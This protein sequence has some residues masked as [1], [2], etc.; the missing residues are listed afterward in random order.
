[1]GK[2]LVIIESA[3]KLKKMKSILGEKYE[4]MASF[5]HILD[6]KEG[7]LSV[8]IKNNF[9]PEYDILKN[10]KKKG[11]NLGFKSKE[12]IVKELK[13]MAKKCSEVLL[14]TD[15]DREGEMIAWSLAHVLGLTDPKRVTFN[16]ITKNEVLKAVKSPKKI[17]NN[18]VDAQRARRILDRIVGFEISPI[19]WKTIQ[20]SLSAGRVQSVVVK[21]IVDKENDISDYFKKNAETYFKGNGVFY[22]KKNNNM[23]A[24]LYQLN[25]SNDESDNDS[26]SDEESN[27]DSDEESNSDSDE[28]K[29]DSDTNSENSD[30]E[31]IKKGTIAK[32]K[33][34][35][36][37]KEIMKK[38]ME[39]KYKIS[40][41]LEK[42]STRNPSAPFI[43]STLQQEAANKLG[44]PVKK[45]MMS[46][47]KLYEAGYI[48]YMRT[49]S[50][51]LSPEAMANI[52]KYVLDKF[53]KEYYRSMDYKSK[54]KNSQEAHEAIRPTDV[55][56]EKIETNEKIGGDEKRLYNLILKRTIASQMSPAKFNVVDIIIDISK[57]I[58]YYYMARTE[59]L[60]FAGFLRI[61]NLKN[62]D[63]DVNNNGEEDIDE[64]EEEEE[65]E[66][67]DKVSIPKKGTILGVD[68]IILQQD[69][70]KPPIRYNEAS[71]V[72]KLEKLGIGRPSTY[73]TNIMKIQE[74]GYVEVKN[75]EGIKK[76]VL[77][78]KWNGKGKEVKEIKKE[79]VLGKETNKMMPT[80]MGIRVNDFLVKNFSKIMDYKF[81]SDMEEELDV[82]ASGKKKWFNVLDKFY[83]EFHPTIEELNK[84][85][86][87]LNDENMR[88]LG[89]HPESGYEIVATI[90]KY[91]PVVKMISDNSKILYAPIQ[92]PLKLETITLKDAVKLFEYPKKL[93]IINK[94][95]VM[96]NKGKYGLYIKYDNAVINLSKNEDYKDKTN[97]TI[98]D[99]KKLLEERKKNYLWEGT[100]DKKNY[101]VKDGPYGKYI[102]IIDN[103]KKVVKPINISLPDDTDIET[104]SIKK[105]TEIVKNSKNKQK[106]YKNDTDGDNK[107]GI[108]NKKAVEKKNIEKDIEKDIEKKTVKKRET[109][110]KVVEKKIIVKGKKNNS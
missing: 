30:D 54:S 23:K 99:A 72:R 55:F 105:I 6:L 60:K 80:H 46:A 108:K 17:D 12:Q 24:V 88:K 65:E 70:E 64:E 2:T 11:Q 15:E 38:M 8:D 45:T 103:N 50:V 4:V 98:D 9:E 95:P 61:Y 7:S 84:K 28:D 40:N 44:F 79:A 10:S 48:T 101:Y 29:S 13:M 5:G 26:D 100:E 110:K 18:M 47:Q 1:M 71:L 97:I 94:K 58:N 49:D 83:K 3:G 81:T 107:E 37:S 109:T 89:K 104:L 14:A 53:G 21:I 33:S 16:S 51:S 43:T 76:D 25:G 32:I 35:K 85:E 92:E 19:L 74:I 39:S 27:N 59:E 57:L 20:G 67:E 106:K 31:N 86:I 87:N 22:A 90:A 75:M 52:K 82:I 93:G 34:E 73:A 102:S 78:L 96:L 56:T 91:G 69:Y 42:E 77:T 36:E 66:E 62:V 68:N 63:N 41:I